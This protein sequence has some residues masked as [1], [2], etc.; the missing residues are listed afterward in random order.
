MFTMF[1]AW[2]FISVGLSLQV[3]SHVGHMDC[4]PLVSTA[5]FFSAGTG[6]GCT[7]NLLFLPASHTWGFPKIRGT[8]LGVPIKGIGVPLF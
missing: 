5:D 2:V 4:R 7:A 8:I 6:F 3:V 1:M